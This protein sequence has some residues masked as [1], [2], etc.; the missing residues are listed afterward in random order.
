LNTGAGI[1][2]I[3][4]MYSKDTT[5]GLAATSAH[6]FKAGVQQELLQLLL[7]NGAIMTA[8]PGENLLAACLANGRL[9]AAQF[10]ASRGAEVNLEAAAGLGMTGEVKKFFREDGSLKD[11][12]SVR[13]L[14]RGFCS[15]CEYGMHETVIFLLRRGIDAH[16]FQEGL[17]WAAVGGQVN[18]MKVLLDWGAPL[19]SRNQ[20]GG[21]VLGAALWG[22]FNN[23]AGKD[24]KPI[25]RM[26]VDAGADTTVDGLAG[27]VEKV[28]Q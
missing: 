1:N 16:F 14:Q 15:A 25:I 3:A 11:D 9:E 4:D 13:Q 6:P 22:A 10:L 8:L 26:L 21:T 20:H 17:H 19:E 5:I 18:V 12:I 28:L 24:F 23:D 2:D 27:Y 7:D